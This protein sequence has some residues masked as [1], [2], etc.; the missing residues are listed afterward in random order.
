MIRP[1]RL[2]LRAPGETDG[3][4][5]AVDLV[6]DDII[7]YG[8]SILVIGKTRGLPLRARLVGGN[9]EVL[10][11]GVTLPLAW[12]PGDAHVLARR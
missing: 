8:D 11:P 9:P 1:E 6:V 12:A 7:N 2:R 4:D 5:N 3:A 10:R